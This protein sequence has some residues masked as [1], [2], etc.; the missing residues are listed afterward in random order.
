MLNPDLEV[1]AQT[2][3]DK[4]RKSASEEGCAKLVSVYK[5]MIAT[6]GT[7]EVFHLS[8]AHTFYPMESSFL[9]NP[10]G[11]LGLR[12]HLHGGSES[13]SIGTVRFLQDTEKASLI[14]LGELEKLP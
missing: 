10:L 6:L 3:P 8:C 4:L 12:K 11:T 2:K 5:K 7:L 13:V 14:K 9:G 1:L